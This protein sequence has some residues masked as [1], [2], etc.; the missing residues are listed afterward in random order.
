MKKAVLFTILIFSFVA[1]GCMNQKSEVRNRISENDNNTPI[2]IKEA[3][4]DNQGNESQ[5]TPT[6]T[7]KN[8]QDTKNWRTYEKKDQNVKIKYHKNWYYDRDEQAEKKLGYDLYVGFAESPEILSQGAPYPIEFMVWPSKIGVWDGSPCEYKILKEQNDKKYVLKTCFLNEYENILDKMAENFGFLNET[9]DDKK[10]T[11]SDWQV[12]ENEEYGFEFS[13]PQSLNHK[14]IKKGELN[15]CKYN[16]YY[17]ILCEKEKEDEILEC[18]DDNSCYYYDD[19]NVVYFNIYNSVDEFSW[20]ATEENF[21]GNLENFLKKRY[22][23]VEKI[24]INNTESYKTLTKDISDSENIIILYDSK[25][26]VFSIT[27][28]STKKYMDIFNKIVN[29]FKFKNK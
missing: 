18:L 24:N 12:Y 3:E 29:S 5:I 9:K 21:S 13:Y 4:N 20:C 6:S 17:H 27:V 19:L 22:A 25:I 2:E 14:K 1:A 26:I 11:I 28:G 16:E 23:Q 7:N 15:I 10:Q 8:I